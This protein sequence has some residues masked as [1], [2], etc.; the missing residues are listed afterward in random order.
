MGSMK[1]T[2]AVFCGDIHSNFIAV[3]CGDGN[4]LGYNLDTAECLYGYGCDNKGAVKCLKINP[5]RKSII[6]GGDSGE[7]LQLMF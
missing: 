3:G 4:M 7:A 5:K 6:T 1:V 2:D